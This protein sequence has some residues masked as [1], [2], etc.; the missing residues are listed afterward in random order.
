MSGAYSLCPFNR[1]IAN[2]HCK[3]KRRYECRALYYSQQA[4]VK[5]KLLDFF[6]GWIWIFEGAGQVQKSRVRFFLGGMRAAK[7]DRRETSTPARST[8]SQSDV[9]RPKSSARFHLM[10]DKNFTLCRTNFI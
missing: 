9:I 4:K 5:T 6:A 3:A 7:F 10:T 2:V 1:G 8:R